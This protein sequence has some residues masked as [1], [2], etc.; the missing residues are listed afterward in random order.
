[1]SNLILCRGF[2]EP[3]IDRAVIDNLKPFLK[4]H[5]IQDANYGDFKFI[6]VRFFND[7]V[8]GVVAGMAIAD[9]IGVGHSNGCAILV[10]AAARTNNI[11]RLIFINP[12]LDRDTVFPASLERIDVFHNQYDFV[13]TASRLLRFH[14]WGDMGNVGYK[15]CDKRVHN[16]ETATLFNAVGHSGVLTHQSRRLAGYIEDANY[17]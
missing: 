14:E 10:R 4:N 6:G 15:G 9:S 3:D 1:M 13:V 11:K 12:A 17:I 5:K 16:H 8:S 2:N 7:N